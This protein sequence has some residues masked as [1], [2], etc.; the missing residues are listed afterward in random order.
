MKEQ[1]TAK[2]RSE[3]AVRD[4]RTKE[5]THRDARTREVKTKKTADRFAVIKVSNSVKL[6]M[7]YQSVGCD[8]GIE[9]PWP[10]STSLRGD[11]LKAG[12]D[13]AYQLIDD[14]LAERAAEIDPLL[15]KLARKYGRR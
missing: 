13:F 10:V 8:V 1:K 9:L 3:L 15:N 14:E 12:F 2:V 5:E 4:E 6:A 7:G 11:E